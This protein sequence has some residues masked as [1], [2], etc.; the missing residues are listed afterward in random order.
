MTR[1]SAPAWTRSMR[2]SLFGSAFPS[3]FPSIFASLQVRCRGGETSLRDCD[4]ARW[5][6]ADTF[7]SVGVTP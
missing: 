7:I 5:G 6:F 4:P 3:I 1:H 2:A